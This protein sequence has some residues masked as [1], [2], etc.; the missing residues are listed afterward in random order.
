M[1]APLK[2]FSNYALPWLVN[3]FAWDWLALLTLTVG[4]AMV[5]STC[6]TL[7]SG[8][9]ALFLPLADRLFGP[10]Q[11]ES[12]KLAFVLTLMVLLN[13]PP[14]LLALSGQPMLEV[15]LLAK[16]VAATV[17]PPMLL[18]FWDRMHP[19]AAM[20]G[21]G[22]G[23]A[24]LVAVLTVGIGDEGFEQLMGDGGYYTR[25]AALA[26]IIV[27]AVSTVVTVAVSLLAFP[28][29]RFKGYEYSTSL[30]DGPQI[31]MTRAASCDFNEKILARTAPYDDDD[32]ALHDVQMTPVTQMTNGYHDDDYKIRK[33]RKVPCDD[34]E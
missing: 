25:L 20:A 21:A 18:G 26:L 19:R 13:L 28:E 24:S 33:T 34:P 2:D 23:L 11:K 9:I 1:A 14:A 4:T 30:L 7:Q 8:M 27:M 10:N 5:A 6:D 16:L 15:L 3:Y 12:T 29:Y 31:Q 22:A 32:K 17:V